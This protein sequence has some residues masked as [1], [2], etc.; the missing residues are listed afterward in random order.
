MAGVQ[1]AEH[2]LDV[3]IRKVATDMG[4]RLELDS[5]GLGG[6]V[7]TPRIRRVRILDV[8]VAPSLIGK[9]ACCTRPTPWRPKLAGWSWM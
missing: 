8:Q 3:A 1:H 6:D 2:H 9:L 5:G 4:R 7:V